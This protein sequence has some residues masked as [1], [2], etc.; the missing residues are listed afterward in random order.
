MFQIASILC[1]PLGQVKKNKKELKILSKN[2]REIKIKEG[3]SI[4]G[5]SEYDYYEFLREWLYSKGYKVYERIRY[6]RY[7]FDLIG[8]KDDKIIL[9]EVKDKYFRR[10]VKQALKK[11]KLGLFSEIYVAYPFKKKPRVN[12]LA[13]YGIGVI[14][15]TRKNV[16]LKSKS[17]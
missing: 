1:F 5:M 8:V 13:K 12:W 2:K 11:A 14:D 9:I 3:N 7:E 15:L 4:E 6:D 10:L 17:K 16:V